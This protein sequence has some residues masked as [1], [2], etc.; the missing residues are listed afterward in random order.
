M[1]L[2][3]NA[4]NIFLGFTPDYLE[5]FCWHVLF[6]KDLDETMLQKMQ[7]RIEL[8]ALSFSLLQLILIPSHVRF[9]DDETLNG[10]NL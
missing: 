7:T 2:T 1:T 4:N 3:K 5:I 9:I 8:S 10:A 6:S